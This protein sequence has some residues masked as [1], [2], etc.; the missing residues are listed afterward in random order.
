M[1]EGQFLEFLTAATVLYILLM[2]I[3]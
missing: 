2:V 1:I 3:R